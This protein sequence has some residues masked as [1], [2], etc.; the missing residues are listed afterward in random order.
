[1]KYIYIAGPYTQGDPV[2]NVRAALAAAD[3]LLK[4]GLVP[5]VP[6][7]TH[8]WHTVSPKDYEIWLAYDLEW[9][10]KCD[11]VLRLPG[12]SKGADGEVTYAE[13]RGIPVFYHM[14]SL[15]DKAVL[16][17]GGVS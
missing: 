13:R 12:A 1:M 11:A 3:E 4:F 5:F 16:Q 17:F 2:L 10:L 6:H 15:M 7:L 9:L 8:L 14:A